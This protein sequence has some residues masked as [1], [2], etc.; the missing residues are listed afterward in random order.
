M[1]SSEMPELIGM[2]DRIFVMSNG[3]I[4]SEYLKD[5]ISQEKIFF[6]SAKER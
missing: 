1:I 6:D 2:S 4:V 3:K 5:E